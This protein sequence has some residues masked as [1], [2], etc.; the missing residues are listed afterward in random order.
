MIRKII[1]AV[2]V[3]MSGMAM[4]QSLD[5][6][7]VE[8]LVDTP[9]TCAQLLQEARLAQ[10]SG[11]DE[12]RYLDD[13]VSRLQL[14]LPSGLWQIQPNRLVRALIRVMR[15]TSLGP[16]NVLSLL[17]DQRFR[18]AMQ[19]RSKKRKTIKAPHESTALSSCLA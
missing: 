6:K 2:A 16:R 9:I 5:Q 7:E 4:M 14:M 13:E 10:Y 18:T 8:V 3:A 12:E 19:R 1:F 17:S 11:Y 15:A